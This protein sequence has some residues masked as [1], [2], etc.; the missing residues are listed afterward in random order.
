MRPAPAIGNEPVDRN[1]V[2]LDRGTASD[3]A[4]YAPPAHPSSDAPAGRGGLLVGRLRIGPR[5]LLIGVFAGAVLV[6]LSGA[7]L[8]ALAAVGLLAAVIAGGEFVRS[9]CGVRASRRSALSIIE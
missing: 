6:A 2:A 9:T 4:A 5:A 7:F 1:V 3:C 8:I